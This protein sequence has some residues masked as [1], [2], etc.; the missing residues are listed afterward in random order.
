MPSHAASGNSRRFRDSVATA[1]RGCGPRQLHIRTV[2]ESGRNDA[3]ERG[4]LKAAPPPREIP[5]G[6]RHRKMSGIFPIRGQG[7][8]LAADRGIDPA[9][10][11]SNP[12]E[13]RNSKK[14]GEIHEKSN[15]DSAASITRVG[16]IEKFLRRMLQIDTS[17]NP[18]SCALRRK[19]NWT[20]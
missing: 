10:T 12:S 1:P 3:S 13:T 8:L 15:A 9:S 16:E 4:I 2:A 7:D 11:Q 20:F 6:S 18:K 17:L 14:S 19:T 5:G